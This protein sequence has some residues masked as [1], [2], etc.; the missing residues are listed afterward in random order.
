[1]INRLRTYLKRGE[2]AP[3]LLKTFFMYGLIA[4]SIIGTKVLIARLYGQE[5][6]GQFSYF[7]SL[8]TVAFLFTSFGLPEAITQLVVKNHQLLRPIVKK[9]L[10]WIL[11]ISLVVSIPLI[12]T[13]F[14]LDT[15]LSKVNFVVYIST[16][17]LFYVMYCIFRAYKKF[18]EGT[19]YSLVNRFIFIATVIIGAYL[20]L[21]FEYVLTGLSLALFTA[22]IVSLPS[23]IKLWKEVEIRSEEDK[24]VEKEKENITS[25]ELLSVALSLALMQAGFYL[26]RE[27][28]ILIISYLSNFTELGLYSA[29]SSLSNIIRLI[30]Y[31]FPVVILPMAVASRYKISASFWKIMKILVPFSLLVLATT[32]LFVPLLYGKEYTDYVLPIALV[33]SSA[34]MVIYSYFNSV[35]VGENKVSSNY[36]TLIT[37]DFF[38]TLV[39][40]TG[41]T[42]LFIKWWGIIGAPIATTITLLL[43]IGL[44]LYG[45]KKL[46][47]ENLNR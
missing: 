10:K 46:R 32:Y 17:T 28:D 2:T 47:Q 37:I 39:V 13:S 19:W 41:L 12:S 24:T 45:I 9:A 1:M 26:L 14:F 31:V 21:P 27:T 4:L 23:L 30:A 35:L 3:H 16:Y 25:K 15:S 36:L 5:E 42:I 7:F 40:N 38:I 33:V 29:H 20:S 11:S 22:S 6:L 34:L 44:N 43:K 8:V 18:V